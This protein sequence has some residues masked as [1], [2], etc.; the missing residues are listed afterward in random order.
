MKIDEAKKELGEQLKGNKWFHSVALGVVE[1]PGKSG[2]G[3]KIQV[4]TVLIDK[5]FKLKNE[6]PVEYKGFNVVVERRGN[7]KKGG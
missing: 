6:V 4:I 5:D 3:T 2:A 7:I 1:M